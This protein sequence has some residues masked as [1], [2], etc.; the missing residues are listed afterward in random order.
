MYVS[1]RLDDRL[2]HSAPNSQV[3]A[4]A[5]PDRPRERSAHEHRRKNDDR[6][7]TQ[8]QDPCR[9]RRETADHERSLAADD[10]EPR[11][12]GKRRA[13]RGEQERRGALQGVLERE[14]GPERAADHLC[15]HVEGIVSR[16]RHEGPE[17]IRETTSAATGMS[18][19]SRRGPRL[20]QA[21][22]DRFGLA[23]AAGV[24]EATRVATSSLVSAKLDSSVA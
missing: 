22:P 18:T 12:R 15:V 21:I 4:A 6:R 2:V 14:P 1:S 10:D 24:R 20:S 8:K 7:S 16:E 9:R 13:E 5:D 11:A 23:E 3:A 19:G 17:Q